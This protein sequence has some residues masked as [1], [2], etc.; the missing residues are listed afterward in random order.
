MIRLRRILLAA[1]WIF[2]AAPCRAIGPEQVLVLGN[3]NSP[4]SRSVCEYYARAR[5]IPARQ[6]LLLPMSAAEEINRQ[7]F[8][9]QIAGPIAAFLRKHGWKD[10]ILVLVT[11]AGMPLKISGSGGQSTTAASVDSELALLYLALQGAQYPLAGARANPYYGRDEPFRHPDFPMYLVARLAAYN[12]AD[13]R[14]I[15]DRSLQARNRGVVA[16]D[17]RGDA[18]DDGDTWLFS[19]AHRLPAA[20]VHIEETPAVLL[21]AR[22]VIGYASWGSNDPNRKKRNVNFEFLP[23][24][25][26]TEYVSTDARTL[27]EPPP[28]WELGD[29]KIP[30]THFAGSPQSMAADWLRFG[31]TAA[32]GHV[33]EP[34]LHFTPRPHIL[35][36]NYLKGMTLAESFYA[37]IPALSWMNVLLGDPLCRLAP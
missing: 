35:F 30:S 24:A 4:L 19:A 7:A 29:W 22:A 25:A 27:S 3:S 12:F 5:R 17:L 33:Y 36:A 23:G 18:F 26:V 31:A 1:A 32:T 2:L 13:I 11:T 20:R 8:Q 37:S 21:G 16:L 14:A 6:V 34:Y 28:G 15:I 10:R 9:Q